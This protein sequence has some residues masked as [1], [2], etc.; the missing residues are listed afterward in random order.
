MPQSLSRILVH[1]TFSTKDRV[2]AIA[3]PDLRQSL[4]AYVGGI[5]RNMKCPS[6]IVGSVTD[7]MHVLYV[8]TRTDT[9][10]DVAESVKK[11]SSRWIKEQKSDVKDPYLTKFAWQSG[12]AAFSVSESNADAVKAYIERQEEHHKR[13]TFQEEYRGFL[14]RH[15]VD[16]DERYVWD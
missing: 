8:Q 12:Y 6:I 5:L 4:N 11:E 15:G 7:H 13:M 3:Y 16:F 1:M 9:T 14:Q 2:R 10:S